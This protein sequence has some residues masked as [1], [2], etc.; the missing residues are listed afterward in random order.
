M[1]VLFAPNT[2]GASIL[3]RSGEGIWHGICGFFSG[4]KVPENATAAEYATFGTERTKKMSFWSLANCTRDAMIN[5]CFD[6]L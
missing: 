3:E 4:D 6:E 2:F 1:Y 5:S